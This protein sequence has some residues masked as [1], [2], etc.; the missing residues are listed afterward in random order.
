MLEHV[1]VCDDDLR[2]AD[3]RQHLLPSSRSARSRSS[4]SR[5]P[6]GTATN[7]IRPR[8]RANRPVRNC[9]NPHQPGSPIP[10]DRGRND[11]REKLIFRA[12]SIG[13]PLQSP[14]RKMF[15]SPISENRYLLPPVPPHCRGAS[16]PSR[17]LK[18]DA[19]DAIGDARRASPARTAKSC[20]PG[21]PTLRSSSQKA[22]QRAALRA[23]GARQP[24]PRGDHV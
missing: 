22:A 20:G 8:R 21:L 13:S 12:V 2:A 4:L 24:G 16:R 14:A 9:A 17:T 1:V 3:V 6:R 15:R 18:R 7:R 5:C 19:M 10:F 11:M 23:T